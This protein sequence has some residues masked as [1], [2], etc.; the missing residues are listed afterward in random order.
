MS[1][2]SLYDLLRREVKRMV[3]GFGRHEQGNIHPL[4]MHEVEKYIIEVVLEETNFNFVMA[5][6]IL[7]IG[8]STLYRKIEALHIQDRS[9]PKKE[10]L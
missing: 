2:L 9:Q 6:K 10:N 7:G 4:I 8:R 3:S 5:S 1:S